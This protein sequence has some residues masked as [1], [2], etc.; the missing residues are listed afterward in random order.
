MFFRFFSAYFLAESTGMDMRVGD[1]LAL[2]MS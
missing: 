2:A 1:L